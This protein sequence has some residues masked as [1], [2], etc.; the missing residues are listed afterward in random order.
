MSSAKEGLET[1]KRRNKNAEAD[2]EKIERE[3]ERETEN[4]RGGVGGH[5]KKEWRGKALE[6]KENGEEEREKRI[7]SKSTD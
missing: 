5:K 6:K 3:L 1:S 4:E 7:F 2:R